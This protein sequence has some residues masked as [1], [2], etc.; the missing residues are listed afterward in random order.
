MFK[1]SHKERCADD[2]VLSGLSAQS[3]FQNQIDNMNFFII[4]NLADHIIFLQDGVD[5]VILD[6]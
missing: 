2:F 5:E 6:K 3:D 1:H 4:L